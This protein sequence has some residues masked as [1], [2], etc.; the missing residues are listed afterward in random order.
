MR[1]VP[2]ILGVLLA[3]TACIPDPV[4]DPRP[5]MPD[6]DGDG[7]GFVVD[8]N[9]EDAAVNPDAEE[10]CDGIDN[11]CDG[12]VDELGATGSEIFY[13]DGDQDG[14]GDP[15]GTLEACEPPPDYVENADDCDDAQG[16]VYP[17][18][19]E[20]CDD[21]DNDCDGEIDG[22]DSLDARTFYWDFD[23]DGFGDLDRPVRAC[24]LD[25]HLVDDTRDCDDVD[26]AI[27]PAAP[28]VCDGIDNDC[29]DAIDDDDPSV[30]PDTFTSW[31][32]DGDGDG[33]GL[34]DEELMVM[35]CDAGEGYAPNGEDC[36]DADAGVG[37][38]C[39]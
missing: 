23:G 10:A 1:S 19:D 29:D 22:P 16:S 18:A 6:A 4:L 35:A 9:D 3:A 37:N 25:R 20:V 13:V 2:L 21:L 11:D 38:E 8:C 33:F 28:E 17:G 30:N 5:D 14:F 15:D 31:F 26:P 34:F 36:D 12:L 39:L 32:P 27:N 24:R 7:F